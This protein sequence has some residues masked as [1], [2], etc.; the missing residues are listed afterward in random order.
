MATSCVW[1]ATTVNITVSFVEIVTSRVPHRLTL[2]TSRNKL[3]V[4]ITHPRVNMVGSCTKVTCSC[5]RYNMS[6]GFKVASI[7]YK[8]LTIA[9]LMIISTKGE[10]QPARW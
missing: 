7:N 8:K 4:K 1:Q 3:L 6:Q 9:E 10:K 2:L 5:S